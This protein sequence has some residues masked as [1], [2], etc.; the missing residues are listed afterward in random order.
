MIRQVPQGQVKDSHRGSH[1]VREPVAVVMIEKAS[2]CIRP[3]GE[4][5]H[6]YFM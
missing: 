6:I 5:P 2:S 4:Y 1:R 3:K